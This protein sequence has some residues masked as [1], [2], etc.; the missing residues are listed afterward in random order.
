MSGRSD[1]MSGR[2]KGVSGRNRA[3]RWGWRVCGSRDD[4]TWSEENR[5]GTVVVRNM[6]MCLT[7]CV[8]THVIQ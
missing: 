4:V 3:V 8:H 5:E 7:E 2:S 1:G 6:Y